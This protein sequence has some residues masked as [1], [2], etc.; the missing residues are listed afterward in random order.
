[1]S[2]LGVNMSPHFLVLS[3]THRQNKKPVVLRPIFIL[4]C[5]SAVSL[6]S[7]QRMWR[8]GS[9]TGWILL[10][11]RGPEVIL[12][13]TFTTFLTNGHAKGPG[14]ASASRSPLVAC[15]T[16]IFYPLSVLFSGHPPQLCPGFSTRK[17]ITA[18]P[19]RRG[20]W[21]S[22]DVSVIIK[23][24]RDKNHLL[25]TVEFDYGEQYQ[26]Y[27]DQLPSSSLPYLLGV[28]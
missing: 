8:R 27:Q 6:V 7:L 20:T 22:K 19:H 18:V 3:P 14:S 23:E 28:R 1:M 10:L 26:R 9:R 5:N 11:F 15:R 17:A 21:Q 25:I 2:A 24:A 16:Y 12:T 4:I 13:S